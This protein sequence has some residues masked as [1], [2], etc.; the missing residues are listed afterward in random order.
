MTYGE[1]KAVVNKT[2]PNAENHFSIGGGIL[3]KMPSWSDEQ[4]NALEVKSYEQQKDGDNEN[5][6]FV[7]AK[8][9]S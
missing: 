8:E 3:L 9:G 5:W 2:Y 7:T 1:F 6:F 4:L